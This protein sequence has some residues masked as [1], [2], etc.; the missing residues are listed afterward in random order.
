MNPLPPPSFYGTPPPRTTPRAALV[1][2]PVTLPPTPSGSTQP[3]LRAPKKTQWQKADSIVKH[4]TSEFRSLGAFLE[5]LF[6]VRDFSVNDP[7]TNS[8]KLMVTSFLG[9]ESNAGMGQIIELIYRHPRSRPPNANSESGL[10][11]SL[12]GVKAPADIR[13]TRPALSTWALQTVGPEMRSQIGL[14]TQNDPDN[15]EDTTQLRASSN[16]R[17]KNV[18]LATW[19]DFGKV[20]IPWIAETYRRRAPAVWYITEC[21]AAPTVNGAIVVRKRRPH[22]TV[23]EGYFVILL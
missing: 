20:S 1:N 10:Y 14:L 21:M 7:R 8:H 16:G 12:L 4:I 9:G 17:A 13:F 6:H 11:F 5:I 23:R 19:D 22:P 3:R 2:T 18:R 15:P